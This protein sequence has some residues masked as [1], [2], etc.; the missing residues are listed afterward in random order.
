MISIAYY[1]V[2]FVFTMIYILPVVVV[3]IA[4]FLF[5]KERVVLHWVSR[6]WAR[7]LFI[8]NPF[9]K[10]RVEGL[11]R[12]D[13]TKPY[14][15]ITNHQA[16]LDIPLLYIHPAN[17]KWVSKQ[18]VIKMPIFGQVLLMHGDIPIKRGSAASAREMMQKATAR[19]KHGTSI[20]MF[21]EGTRTKDGRVGRFKEGAF[22]LAKEAGVGLQPVVIEGTGSVADGWRLKPHH[23]ITVHFLDP[24]TAEQVAQATPKE[25]MQCAEQL[26]TAE[27]RTMRADIY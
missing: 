11:E 1:L 16:M 25:M 3:F 23:T 14:V 9:W 8:L 27:H 26:I 21:P 4:T 24:I 2:I 17:F 18:E 13:R 12:V 15:V 20:I 19:L 7:S 5:D 6:F 22:L 10:V